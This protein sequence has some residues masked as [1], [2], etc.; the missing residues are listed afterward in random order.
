MQPIRKTSVKVLRKWS[1]FSQHSNMFN[2]KQCDFNPVPVFLTQVRKFL[3]QSY[4]RNK[5]YFVKSAILKGRRSLNNINMKA[6]KN[7]MRKQQVMNEMQTILY[8]FAFTNI[9]VSQNCTVLLSWNCYIGFR[10]YW[11][12]HSRCESQMTTL[13]ANGQPLH[14]GNQLKIKMSP[15]RKYLMNLPA[16]CESTEF[17]VGLQWFKN[18]I[19]VRYRATT[20]V[21]C[22]QIVDFQYCLMQ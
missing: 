17:T 5:Y 7:Q 14:S 4:K 1:M 22:E 12:Y 21:G 16:Q 10:L 13:A 6:M 2:E 19:W 3:L 15:Q 11:L 9:N 18:S 8:L 20:T